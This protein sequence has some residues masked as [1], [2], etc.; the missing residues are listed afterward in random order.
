MHRSDVSNMVRQGTE[1]TKSTMV[2]EDNTAEAWGSG[3]LPVFATPAMVLL[4]EETASESVASDLKEGE[5]TVGTY[6]DV[7]HTS[8]TPIGMT[9]TCRTKL[10]EIDR[11]RLRFEVIVFDDRGEIGVGYHERFVVS[12]EKFMSKAQ[13]KL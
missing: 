1:G 6:V 2:T 11:A 3:T 5:T 7:R 13:S 10:I 8:A 9:V 12:S 4:I